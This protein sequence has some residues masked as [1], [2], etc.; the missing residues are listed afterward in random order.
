[1]SLTLVLHPDAQAEYDEAFEWFEQLRAGS[2]TP[3]TDA[4]GEVFDLIAAQ[5]RL[6]A[7]VY[8]DVRHAPV[9]GYP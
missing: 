7:R 6:H 4:V 5:P 2:G 1:M 3:F 8:K 9:S